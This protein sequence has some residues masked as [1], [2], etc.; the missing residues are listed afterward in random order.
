MTEPTTGRSRR[1]RNV[2]G[3]SPRRN[4]YVALIE[5]GW[6]SL[7]V[8]RYAY[9][10]YGED[11]PASTIRSYCNKHAITVRGERPFNL[12]HVERD[13]PVDV[14]GTRAELIHLQVARLRVDFAREQ[15]EGKLL[16]T[17][18][19]EVLALNT[20]LTDHKADLQDA[21]VMAKLG[22][23]IK[24]SGPAPEPVG[25]PRARSLAEAFGV[26]PADEVAIARQLHL[27]LVPAQAQAG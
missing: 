3:G 25:L 22:Q 19:L 24:L 10:R 20:M 2:F 6:S 13:T 5:A 18:R 7:A 21:G 9:H 17:T 27:S 26:D 4:E 23:E 8:E 16:P 12:A 11:I 14:L 15:A 1:R